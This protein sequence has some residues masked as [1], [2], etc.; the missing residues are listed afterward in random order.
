LVGVNQAEGDLDALADDRA[1]CRIAIP[2]L[3]ERHAA[4]VPVV[5]LRMKESDAGRLA[6]HDIAL[7]VQN[8][9]GGVRALIV[10]DAVDGAGRDLT[11]AANLQR[12]VANVDMGR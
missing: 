1:S 6:V 12:S 4:L 3:E 7:R 5:V 2:N 11:T 10:V 9:L 8:L